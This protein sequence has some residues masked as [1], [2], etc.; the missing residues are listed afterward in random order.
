[1]AAQS[2][3]RASLILIAVGLAAT[4]ALGCDSGYEDCVSNCEAQHAC[5]DIEATASACTASCETAEERADE[6]GCDGE[7]AD[8]QECVAEGDPCDPAACSG[9]RND[10]S[11]CGQDY[12]RD[13]PGEPS[14]A[15]DS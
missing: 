6:L 5:S 9:E 1:M 15:V 8:Y 4:V 12:C 10:Y 7:W 13:N 3:V 14:C 11:E 2:K